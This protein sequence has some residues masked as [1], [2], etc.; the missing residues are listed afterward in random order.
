[1]IYLSVLLDHNA[2]TDNA[3]YLPI[4]SDFTLEAVSVIPNVDTAA[5]GTNYVT[6]SIRDAADAADRDWETALSVPAL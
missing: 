6:I 1:M 4:P 2:G 5:N 3:V